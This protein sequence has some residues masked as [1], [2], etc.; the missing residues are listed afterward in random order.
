MDTIITDMAEKLFSDYGMLQAG[1]NG[2]DWPKALWDIVEENGLPLALVPEQDG[3]FGVPVEQALAIIRIAGK[4]AISIPLGETMVA[5]WLLAEV[6]MPL[7]SGPLS[8]A[9]SGDI[10]LTHTQSGWRVRGTLGGISWGRTASSV[11]ALTEFE[12]ETKLVS[13]R[14]ADLELTKQCNLAGEPWDQAA[15]DKP[16]GSDQVAPITL[17]PDAIYVI[18]ALLRSLA[19]AGAL[20]T[21]LDLSVAYANDRVQFGRSIGK[22]Q[23][24][25]HMLAT[26]ASEVAAARVGAEMAAEISAERFSNGA[27]VMHVA[28]AK[29]RC[30]EA[31]QTVAALA[32]QIHGAIGFTREYELHRLTQRVW[33]WRDEFGAEMEWSQRLGKEVLTGSGDGYWPCITGLMENAET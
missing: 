13:L 7:P 11:I 25:Q 10:E 8:V 15:I 12:G 16:L 19:M 1:E 30:G 23:A 28:A 5:N 29:Q 24:I 14:L 26:M 17:S 4:H 32:H 6:A 33:A 2:E 27:S 21:I 22:F 20:E 9:A 18:G 3:G 31:A